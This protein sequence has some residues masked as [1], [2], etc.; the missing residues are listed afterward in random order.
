MKGK[1]FS[2]EQIIALLQRVETGQKVGDACR[3]LGISEQTYYRWKVKY[4]SM[5]ANEVK[6][7]RDLEQEN[8][9]LKRLLADTMLDNAALKELL[10]KK[11]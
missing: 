7:L 5:T 9:R 11:W 8:A 3:E 2:E 4:G 6:R 10:A 1:A